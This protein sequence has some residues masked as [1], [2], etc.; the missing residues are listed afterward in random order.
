MEQNHGGL[1]QIIFLSKWVILLMEEIRLTSWYVASPIIYRVFLCIQ[2]L[3]VWDFWTINSMYKSKDTS[4][5]VRT[6]DAQQPTSRKHQPNVATTPDKHIFRGVHLS[7]TAW[8]S[9]FLGSCQAA[10]GT[11]YRSVQAFFS[12]YLGKFPKDS[13]LGR[14]GNLRED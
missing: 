3:V 1:V 4:N 10:K 13:R 9:F 11:M 14:L 7:K 8:C 6:N 2:T 5:S 12:C